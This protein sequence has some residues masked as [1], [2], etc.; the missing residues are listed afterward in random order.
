MKAQQVIKLIEKNGWLF[1]RQAGSHKIF[2]HPTKKGIVV[3]PDHG[4]ED[5]R[6]G[7]LNAILKQAGLK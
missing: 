2:K 6:I 3:I 5:L 1:E 4:K 7:T